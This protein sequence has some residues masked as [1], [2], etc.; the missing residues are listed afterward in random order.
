MAQAARKTKNAKTKIVRTKKKTKLPARGKKSAKLKA[1]ATTAKKKTTKKTLAKKVIK[2]AIKKTKKVTK[3][4]VRKI[5]APKAVAPV[6]A[7]EIS[8][9]L[10]TPTPVNRVGVGDLAP[11][12]TLNDTQGQPLTLS[13]CRGKKVVLYFYPKDDTPGC[14]KEACNFRDQL[15]DFTGQDAVVLGVS[16]DDKESHQ[17]FTEKYELNFPLLSDTTKST[18]EAYGVYVQKNIYGNIS[19]GIE[20]STFVIDREGKIA[21]AFRKVSV[22]GH[23]AEVLAALTAI[24]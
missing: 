2:K 9:P 23:N 13:E 8:A 17:K 14:T 7:V 21:A 4:A 18:A 5:A 6:S 20:R 3:K 24:A 10:V 16:F 11:D 12:F 22:D 15:A 19:W 1:K